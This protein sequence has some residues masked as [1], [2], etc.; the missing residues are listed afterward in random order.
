VL[1]SH[2]AKPPSFFPLPSCYGR[3]KE[4]KKKQKKK[5]KKKDEKKRL[6]HSSP[7]PTLFFFTPAAI[8][9]PKTTIYTIL[10]LPTTTTTTTINEKASIPP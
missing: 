5:Q 8:P 4:K 2:A 3:E 7:L 9:F 6:S 10:W 1:R